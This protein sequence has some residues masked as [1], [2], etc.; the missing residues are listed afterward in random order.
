M[1]IRLLQ[2]T[3]RNFKGCENLTLDFGGH[4]ATIYGDNAAGKTTI[5]D[6]MTWLL[7]GKDS[8]GRSDF[9]I[10]PLDTSGQVKDHGAVSEVEAVFMADSCPIKLKKTFYERWSTKRG[11]VEATYDGNTSEY[12][13]DEVPVKKYEF[14]S[15]VAGLVSEDLFRMLTNVSWFCE[16][17]DWKSRRKTL[18]EVCEVPD[19]QE[20]MAAAPQFSGL[21]LMMGHLSLDDFKKKLMSRRKGLNG[22]RSTIPARLDEQKKSV[23]A[24]STIDFTSIEEERN[25]KAAQLEQLSGEMVKL[26]HGSLM[27]SRRNEIGSLKNQLQK[28]INDNNSHRASQLVPVTD[29]RPAMTAALAQARERLTRSSRMAAS[30]KQLMS[31]I[32]ASIERYRTEWLSADGMQFMPSSCPTCGQSLPDAAQKRAKE[33]FEAEKQKKKADA[34]TAANLEKASQKAAAERC[35]MYS[36]DAALAEDEVARLTAALNA[37]LPPAVPEVTDLPE[38]EAQ[39]SELHNQIAVLEAEVASLTVESA[40]VRSELNE[41]IGVLRREMEALEGELAKRSLLDYA[42]QREEALRMEARKTA[43]E[44]EELDKQLFLCEEFIRFK[45]SYIEESINN[46]FQ[47]TRFKLFQEQVN[48]GLADCCEATYNGVPYSSLNNGMRINIGVDV[49]RTVSDHYGLRVPLVVDNAESVVDLLDAGTQ[50]IRLVVSGN[51]KE[52]RCEYGT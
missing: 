28:L 32:K 33:R 42:R 26:N 23:E 41:K 3:I 22:A 21:A 51:D 14:E 29:E 15:R 16:G 19:D 40:S 4:S 47:F 27:D 1:D 8:R 39:S 13:V 5:Y 45:V 2:L 30:E 12:F 10:K 48:G 43:E 20:I 18:L 7:F 31:Q 24:L 52:L 34:V 37:Y 36:N 6:A 25:A 17:M 50:V 44:L 49:I 46:K 38:F 9:E 35:E 11:S